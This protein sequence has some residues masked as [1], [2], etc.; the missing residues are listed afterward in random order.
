MI[1][2]ENG[3]KVWKSYFDKNFNFKL[4][5]IGKLNENGNISILGRNDDVINIRGHRIGTENRSV[6]LKTN[7]IIETAQY[8]FLIKL[9]EIKSCFCCYQKFQKK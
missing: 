5:D 1:K 3:E 6:V 2:V 8:Q 4:F 9:K 7:R